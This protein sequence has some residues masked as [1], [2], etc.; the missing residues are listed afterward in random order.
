MIRSIVLRRPLLLTLAT[1]GLL[2]LVNLLFTV[3]FFPSPLSSTAKTQRDVDPLIATRDMP[4]S[5]FRASTENRKLEVHMFQDPK[6]CE[7][8][9]LDIFREWEGS[10]MANAWQDP[11]Y[12]EIL[13]EHLKQPVAR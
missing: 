8:C 12:R 6:T 1:F 5:P 10:V 7:G 13:K 3:V 4:F 2:V 11:I 9:H